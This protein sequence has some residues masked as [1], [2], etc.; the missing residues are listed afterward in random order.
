[1]DAINVMHV[2]INLLTRPFAWLF[3][4]LHKR[5]AQPVDIVRAMV[6][7]GK[8]QARGWGGDCKRQAPNLYR[9]AISQADWEAFYGLNPKGIQQRAGDMLNRR[10]AEADLVLDGFATVVLYQDLSLDLGEFR[11][12][13]SF[14]PA[15]AG[16]AFAGDANTA[17]T[18]LLT[19]GQAM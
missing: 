16:H 6:R 18:M 5:G 14:A 1:M 13:P 8:S 12:Y 17:E 10:L 19:G 3:R 4:L 2:L 11:V 15:R 9:V 7:A